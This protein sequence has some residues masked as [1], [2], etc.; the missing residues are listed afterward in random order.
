[1]N[2]CFEQAGFNKK[3]KFGLLKNAVMEFEDPSQFVILCGANDD[4]SR[5]KLVYTLVAS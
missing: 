3:A 1:M 4:D 5:K 2:A